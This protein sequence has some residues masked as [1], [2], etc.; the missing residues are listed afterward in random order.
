M[1]NFFNKFNECYFIAEIGVN[2]NGNINLAKKMIYEAK[3][4]GANAVKFQTFK[5]ENLVS[6]GTPKVDYQH[7][8]TSPDESHFEM[9][10]KLVLGKKDHII[11]KKYS[12]SLGLDFLSTPYD[13]DSAKFLL[14]LDIKMFKTASA[15][16]VD[17]P[18][19]NFIAKSLKPS[20]V[21]VGM[22]SLGE[23]E[24][25]IN[26]YRNNKNSNIILLHCVS[27]YPCSDSS[28]N[29]KAIDTLSSAFMTPVGF[30]DHSKGS[31][32]STLS[33][34]YNVKII[35]KHFTLD[36][37]LKG[38]DHKASSTPLE[39]K[40]I[41]QSVRRAEKMIGSG[42]K[43]CQKEENQMAQISRKSI[44]AKKNIN[45]NEPFSYEN[46]TLKRPGTG[47]MS[48]HLPFFIGKQSSSNIQEDQIIKFSD[49]K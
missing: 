45:K 7:N 49:I 38:P 21:S 36:K 13:L 46:L 44:V 8:T 30:S 9:I 11:L 42:I 22:A 37:N 16:I 4:S 40:E 47:I 33:V 2:H 17:F 5:A 10:K 32:A 12:E 29:L 3:N 15:D 19:Q 14:D 27:N 24:D 18:L 25:V 23:I 20:I 41:V 39:F 31:I 43:I 1:D 35:E 48:K 34:V 28:L 26:I 6:R